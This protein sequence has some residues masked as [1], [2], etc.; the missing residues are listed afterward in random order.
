MMDQ[1]KQGNVE[2]FKYF[3]IMIANDARYMRK[4]KS[5]TTMTKA[6]N[7]EKNLFTSILDLYVGKKLAKC[8]V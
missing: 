4:I 7:K 8:Y 3:S 2:Y 1:R 5:R 6:C